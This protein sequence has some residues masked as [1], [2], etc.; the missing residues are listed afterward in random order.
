MPFDSTDY[1]RTEPAK[2]YDADNPPTRMSEAIRMAVA[3]VEALLDRGFSYDWNQ[4]WFVLP[5]DRHLLSGHM[6]VCNTCT[7]GAIVARVTNYEKSVSGF[8]GLGS[9]A[10]ESLLH[11]LSELTQPDRRNPIEMAFNQWP[12]GF[13]ALPEFEAWI[14]PASE[15][16]TAFKRDMLNLAD[17]LEAEGS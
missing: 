17:R 4:S 8:S 12:R 3:D 9:P 16:P 15:D 7:A 6:R 14:T 10:W 11:A 5:K 13:S 2:V 1:Y